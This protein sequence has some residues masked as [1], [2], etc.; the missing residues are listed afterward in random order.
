[1]VV[2]FPVVVTFFIDNHRQLIVSGFL[3]EIP[4]VTEGVS[5]LPFH[6]LFFKLK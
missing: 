4:S 2:E 5:L 1:M 6:L 3:N